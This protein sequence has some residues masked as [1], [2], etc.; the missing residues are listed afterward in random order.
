MYNHFQIIL[1]PS[2]HPASLRNDVALVVLDSSFTLSDNVGMVCLP[3]Q[4]TQPNK[5]NCIATGW[6][7]QRGQYYTTLKKVELAILSSQWCLQFLRAAFLGPFFNLHS[8]FICAGGLSDTC[9]GDGGGPL[10]CPIGDSDRYEQVGIVSWGLAGGG[11]GVPGV[12]VNLGMFRD[13]I[14]TSM[15]LMNFSVN[16][17]KYTKNKL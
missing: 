3:R 14:D 4:D 1:H 10:V 13:W 8:S 2:Y 11:W 9:K 16:S 17:Y 5:M 7:N 6:G 15:R 12:Y